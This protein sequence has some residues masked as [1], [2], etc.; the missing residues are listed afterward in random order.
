MNAA[1]RPAAPFAYS[2]DAYIKAALI[3]RAH[4]QLYFD[5]CN[6]SPWDEVRVVTCLTD[7]QDALERVRQEEDRIAEAQREVEYQRPRFG[8]AV[9]A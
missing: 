4:R 1:N 7:Y 3:L 6:A 8:R 5:A 9:R 2:T